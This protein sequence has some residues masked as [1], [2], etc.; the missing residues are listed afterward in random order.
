MAKLVIADDGIG[1]GE[2]IKV[3]IT[4]ARN[5]KHH[6]KFFSMVNLVFDNQEKYPTQRHL[7]TAIKLEAGWYEDGPVDV[8]GKV[9]Y[10][11][12]G[13]TGYGTVKGRLHELYEERFGKIEGPAVQGGGPVH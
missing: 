2:L 4:K 13:G 10:L 5:L 3:K 12:K 1:Q 11:T 7:L 9:S 8:D 6:R